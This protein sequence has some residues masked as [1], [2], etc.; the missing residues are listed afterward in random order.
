MAQPLLVFLL[1]TPQYSHITTEQCS[2]YHHICLHWHPL[3]HH[4]ACLI[5]SPN[6]TKHIHH[7]PVVFNSWHY[8]DLPIF[9]LLQHAKAFI[10][11]PPHAHKQRAPPTSSLYSVVQ[12]PSACH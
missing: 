8:L 7:T 3:L 4:G 6:S 10:N 11:Q 5:H 9:H 2:P 1:P 12:L